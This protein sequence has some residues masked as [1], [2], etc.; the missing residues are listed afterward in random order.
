M[1]SIAFSA[2]DS[3]TIGDGAAGFFGTNAGA[4]AAPVLRSRRPK[5]FDLIIR[6]SWRPLRQPAPSAGESTA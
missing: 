4:R 1:E 5:F 2:S 3:S 6:V